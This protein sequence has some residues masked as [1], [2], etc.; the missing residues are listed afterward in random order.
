MFSIYLLPL[1][2]ADIFTLLK[3]QLK[4]T[5]SLWWRTIQNW[6]LCKPGSLKQSTTMDIPWFVC[7]QWSAYCAKTCEWMLCHRA[8]VPNLSLTTYPYSNSTDKHVPLQNF[9]QWT[10]TPKISNDKIF[11]DNS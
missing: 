5:T 6:T 9:E 10:C 4:D 8:G 1:T 3:P 2:D 7:R 11:Y